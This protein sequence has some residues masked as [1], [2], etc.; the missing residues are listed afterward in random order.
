MNPVAAEDLATARTQSLASALERE[1]ERMIVAGDLAPGARINENRLAERFGTSRGPIREA[2]RALEG[3]GLVTSV[4]N[5]GFFVRRLAVEEVREVYDVRAALFG[6]AGRL[7]AE[8]VTDAQL[9]RLNGFVAEMDEASRR[10]DFD[11]YYP[12]NLAFH[13]FIV[14]A[15]GN[16]TLADQYRGFVKKLHLFRARSLVQGGGLAVSNREHREM[17]A[18][19]AARDPSWAHEAHW[20]HVAAAKDRLLAVVRGTAGAPDTEAQGRRRRRTIAAPRAAT[21][22]GTETPCPPSSARSPS[23]SPVSS[24]PPGSPRPVPAPPSRSPTRTRSS[25]W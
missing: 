21:G 16:A 20:R 19:V 9:E 10:R 18:A 23:A 17:L 25:P 15:A 12:L 13:G 4:R 3:S 11:A 5:R 7:L 1:V 2:V 24:S 6:L 14:D 8:R 22:E